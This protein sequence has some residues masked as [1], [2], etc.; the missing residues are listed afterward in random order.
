MRLFQRILSHMLSIIWQVSTAPFKKCTK[1]WIHIYLTILT[2]KYHT[3]FKQQRIWQIRVMFWSYL[4]W[5]KL[6]QQITG[7]TLSFSLSLFP[8]LMCFVIKSNFK[9][10]INFFIRSKKEEWGIQDAIGLT[11]FSSSATWSLWEQIVRS[12]SPQMSS[13]DGRNVQI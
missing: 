7:L 4:V 11:A 2:H 12:Q 5:T 6:C 9:I 3:R 10:F 8:L 1:W 13:L